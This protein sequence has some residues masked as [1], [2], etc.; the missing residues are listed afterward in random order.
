M[1]VGVIDCAASSLLEMSNMI[2]F[3]I[4]RHPAVLRGFTLVELLV[5]IAIIGILVA[6][7]LPAIQAA[8]EAARRTQ[9]TNNIR[10]VGIALM[11]FE[12]AN[13]RFPNGATQRY[14]NDAKTGQPFSGDPTMFSWVSTMMPYLEEASFYSKVDWKVPLGQ[15]NSLTPPDTSHHIKFESYTCPSDEPVDIVNNWYGARG[16]YAGNV[17][18][19]FMW[20]NDTSPTQD[21]AFANLN[22]GYSCSPHPF[23]TSHPLGQN[24]EAPNSSLTRFGTFMMNKGRRM[25]EF[26]DGTSK[27][28]AISEVRTVAGEDTRGTLH[29][30][31][32]VMYMHDY[33]PNYIGL[34]DRSRYCVDQ[35]DYAPCQTSESEWRGRWRHFARSA[36]NGGVNLMMV[37]TSVR[38]IPDSIDE[39]TWQAMSTPKGG[40]VVTES[41]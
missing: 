25:S 37:D 4:G 14:G 28:A 24:P 41:I 31:A 34:K 23:S 8:R 2:R 22:P 29:F 20:M 18:I 6:L 38:F 12:T 11:N 5:V 9:C 39:A 30:G 33:P 10:Q 40:E 26:E 13:K 17:G 21:C 19:G 1:E 7:L 15:R 32:G 16:N 35:P 3:V 27:T 36:H